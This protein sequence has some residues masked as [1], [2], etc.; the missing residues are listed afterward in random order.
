MVSILN[1]L[2]YFLRFVVMDFLHF[3]YVVPLT[4]CPFFGGRLPFS[5]TYGLEFI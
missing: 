1:S 3:D 5:I 4:C 2:L